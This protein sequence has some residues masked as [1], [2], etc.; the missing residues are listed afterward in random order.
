[1]PIKNV[2]PY[3]SVAIQSILNQTFT[4]FEFIIIDDG[5]T[6]DSFAIAKKFARLDSRIKLLQSRL[7]GISNTL[8]QGIDIAQADL[9]ARMDGDDI[10]VPTR[11]EKQYKFMQ[12]NK[13]VGV[14]GSWIEL[15]G[16]KNEVWHYREFDS[17]IKNLMIFKGTGFGHNV[18]MIRKGV[19]NKFKYEAKFNYYEDYRLW[20]N[21]A[22]NSDI[23]FYNIQ[24][25]LVKYRIH[26]T[27]VKARK[28]LEQSILR[29]KI[30]R[31]FWI[32]L[33]YKLNDQEYILLKAIRE[34]NL[35]S[36]NR[37]EALNLLKRLQ[38]VSNQVIPDKFNVYTH[39]LAQCSAE[40][41]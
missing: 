38:A 41:E 22:A 1:M 7:G 29:E 10:A 9:I 23:K 6:D 31:D 32:D 13:E 2:E 30:I 17:H 16:H 5:S 15:F 18:V 14:C 20:L 3:L 25:S 19:F 28:A 39:Y 24:E 34:S 33:G 37:N 4:D 12:T 11:F 27:Q 35:S 21:I 8:N 40:S 36:K 26:P